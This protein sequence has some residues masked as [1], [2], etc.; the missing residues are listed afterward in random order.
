MTNYGRDARGSDLRGGDPRIGG[1]A[2]L[3]TTA[4]TLANTVRL[5]GCA[6]AR[7]GECKVAH[8]GNL[9]K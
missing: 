5:L 4:V 1:K 9:A 6:L 7:L 2:L 8:H 3:P